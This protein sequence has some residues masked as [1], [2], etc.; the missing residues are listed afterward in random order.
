LINERPEALSSTHIALLTASLVPW[1]HATKLAMPDDVS[2]EFHEA[3][4]P[5][6]RGFIALLAGLLKSLHLKA[7]HAVPELTEIKLWEELCASD[8]LPEIKR[9]FYQFGASQQKDATPQ[10]DG[11]F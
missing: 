6:I 4:R 10:V 11:A 1:H 7:G 3:E 2:S 8:P 9:A 5:G